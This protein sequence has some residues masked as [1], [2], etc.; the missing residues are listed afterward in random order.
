[1]NLLRCSHCGVKKRR[2]DFA[3]VFTHYTSKKG[4]KRKYRSTILKTCKICYNADKLPLQLYLTVK[5]RKEMRK[6]ANSLGMNTS[7]YIRWLHHTIYKTIVKGET[8]AS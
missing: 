5:E 3:A 6:A 4:V 1:M 7:T 8:N 2:V